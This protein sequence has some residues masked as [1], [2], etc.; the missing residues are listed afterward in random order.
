[1]PH[2]GPAASAATAASATAAA[3]IAFSSVPSPS[4]ARTSVAIASVAATPQLC[5]LPSCSHMHRCVR[6]YLHSNRCSFAPGACQYKIL[7]SCHL[8]N[9]MRKAAVL[10][11]DGGP[12]HDPTSGIG[13]VVQTLRRSQC[14]MQGRA[15]P[16]HLHSL[17]ATAGKSLRSSVHQQDV[18]TG[19]EWCCRVC[20]VGS[21]R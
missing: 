3:S 19:T 9:L 13:S 11:Q 1:M 8:C 21:Q 2:E 16:P 17:S 12:Y 4:V 6:C 10:A 18:L 5:V 14:Y 15:R 7:C 20:A